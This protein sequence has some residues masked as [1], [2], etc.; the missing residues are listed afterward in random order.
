LVLPG[1]FDLILVLLQNHIWE[2]TLLVS[3]IQE[4]SLDAVSEDMPPSLKQ[5]KV[6]DSFSTLAGTMDNKNGLEAMHMLPHHVP[7]NRVCSCHN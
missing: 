1:V 6:V 7:F 5:Q 4:L 2:A 3:K